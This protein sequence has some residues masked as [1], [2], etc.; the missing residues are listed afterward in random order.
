MDYNANEN[1][2]KSS[3]WGG[4]LA[5]SVIGALGLLALAPLLSAFK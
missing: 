5:Y 1:P 2:K 4:I 3:Y